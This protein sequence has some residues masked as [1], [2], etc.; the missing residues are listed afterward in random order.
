[1]TALAFCVGPAALAGI[2]PPPA[3]TLD[4]TPGKRWMGLARNALA[5]GETAQALYA[6]D[7]VIE[8][9]PDLALAHLA[10][11]TVLAQLGRDDD[12]S[13]ALGRALT[14]ATGRPEVLGELAKACAAQGHQ[15]LALDLL[16]DAVR[17][18]PELGETLAREPAF[19]D[20]PAYLQVLGRL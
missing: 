20:H 15:A 9:A 16:G 10:R 1:M 12:A 11:A 8:D 3:R 19:S 2:V 6:F 5:R 17:A 14:L 13:S 4:L 7:R 18:R